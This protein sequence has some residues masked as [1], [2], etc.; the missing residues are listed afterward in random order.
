M[1][2]LAGAGADMPLTH[3]LRSVSSLLLGTALLMIGGG[4]L[5]TVL[6]FRMGAAEQPPWLVG[7]VMSMYYA[8]IVLGTSYG[9]KLI[10]GVGHIR[11]FVALGSMMSAATLAHAFLADPWFWGLLR[12]LVGMCAVGMFMCTESWINERT[13]NSTRGQIFALYQITVYLA[14]GVGQFLIN[15][16]DATGFIV[17][18]LMSILMS[19]AIVP[20]AVTRVEAPRLPPRAR[21]RFMRLW[22]TSPTSMTIAS[23]C[24]VILGAFYGVGPLFA[25]LVG[26]DAQR[27]AAFMGTVIVGGLVLQWPMGKLSDVIDRR[28]VILG[29][30]AGTVAACAALAGLSADTGTALLLVGALFGG[31]AFALYPLGVA[32]AFDCAGLDDLVT[33]S[34]GLIMAYGVGAAVGPAAASLFV[35]VGGAGGLFVFCGLVALAITAFVIWRMTVRDTPPVDDQSDFQA[36]PRTSQVIY[37]IDPRRD[38][39]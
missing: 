17:Y 34:G 31:T 9:H 13:E 1:A 15:I 28:K 7:V 36:M 16:P 20:V 2:A 5:S 39:G 6:A 23:G 24:G 35:F 38:G 33:M 22:R 14:Q 30:A 10:A 27:T 32:Y 25:Q 3:S 21:F 19:L 12:A 37:E 11:A 18:L 29:V 4:G 26:L 8:G